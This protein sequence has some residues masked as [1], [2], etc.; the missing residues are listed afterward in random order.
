VRRVVIV[1]S[2]HRGWQDG[3][4]AMHQRGS[5]E[6]AAVIDQMLLSLQE[7]YLAGGFCI[8]SMGCDIG[9]GRMVKECCEKRAVGL[10]EAMVQFNPHLP[11]HFFELLHLS[12]H[13]ALIDVGQEFHIFVTKARISNIEDLVGK[14]HNCRLPYQVYGEANQ[15]VECWQPPA[16]SVEE[17]E[18]ITEEDECTA[19]NS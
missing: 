4:P 17:L 8:L 19:R 16:L 5:P 10:M 15:I 2:R 18:Q 3:V 1:G 9:F 11:K 7:K 6:D 13:A 12:R 14:L